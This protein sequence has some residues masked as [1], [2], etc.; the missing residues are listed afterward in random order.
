MNDK[1]KRWPSISDA[2]QTRLLLGLCAIL[3]AWVVVYAPRTCEVSPVMDEAGEDVVAETPKS[4][5]LSCVVT[6]ESSELQ[7][8]LTLSSHKSLVDAEDQLLACVY[9]LAKE[10][11]QAISL[12]V[13]VQTAAMDWTD[14]YGNETHGPKHIVD[15]KVSAYNL[16]EAR[17]Y[18]SLKHF[19]NIVQY[20]TY[21]FQLSDSGFWRE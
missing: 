4:P 5:P 11:D 20:W 7:A 9:K 10:Y 8:V 18:Q 2:L 21:T 1:K 12:D 17:K 13:A 15:V 6:A 19:D 3:T 14:F 16:V